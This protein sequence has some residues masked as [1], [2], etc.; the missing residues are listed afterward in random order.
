MSTTCWMPNCYTEFHR[1]FY[2]HTGC[3]RS[4]PQ[5]LM[6]LRP[7]IATLNGLLINERIVEWDESETTL[8][9]EV[10]I[11]SSEAEDDPAIVFGPYVLFGWS[12]R[13]LSLPTPTVLVQRW[14]A[15]SWMR[16]TRR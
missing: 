3:S 4:L 12:D 6:L 5:F 14:A 8:A 10:T 7:F 9:E 13:D 1:K 2:F 11:P 15:R 16:A